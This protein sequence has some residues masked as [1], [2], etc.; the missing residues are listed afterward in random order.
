MGACSS[1]FLIH[2]SI[3]K[4]DGFHAGILKETIHGNC[5]IINNAWDTEHRQLGLQIRWR[6]TG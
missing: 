3:G 1:N 4:F 2:D 6:R 5:H